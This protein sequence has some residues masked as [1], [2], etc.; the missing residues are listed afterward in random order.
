MAARNPLSKFEQVAPE[1]IEHIA[2][3]T[4]AAKPLGPPSE[5]G[6][7][8]LVS[9][10]LDSVLG[11]KNNAH[12]YA[13]TF[14]L[15]F[16]RSALLRRFSE[17]WRT[18]RCLTSE[19]KKRFIA[20]KRIRSMQ[21]NRDDLWTA[22]LMMLENDGKNGGQLVIWAGVEEFLQGALA[23]RITWQPGAPS[24]WF[25]EME[26]TSLIA[27]LLWLTASRDGVRREG[28]SM[29][30]TIG[31]MLRPFIVAGYK[32]PATFAPDSHF[33]LPLCPHSVFPPDFRKSP[34][35]LT[36]KITHYGHDIHLAVP[37]ITTAATLGTVLR[38]EIRQDSQDLPNDVSSLPRNREEANTVG[39]RGA[40]LE[41]VLEFH[42][43]NRIRV[44][45]RLPSISDVQ[46]YFDEDEE[47]ED[48]GTSQQHDEDWSRLAACYDPWLEDPP[49]RG[50]VYTPGA[51]CG[52]WAGRILQPGFSS[53]LDLLNDSSRCSLHV[54]IYQQPMYLHLQEHHCLHP[55]DPLPISIDDTNFDDILHAWLPRGLDIRR[56]EDHIE[57]Y[58]PASESYIRYETYEP[59]GQAHYSQTTSESLA[60]GCSTNNDRDG[61]AILDRGTNTASGADSL[62]SSYVDN[63][64]E[65][66]DTVSHQCSGIADILITGETGERHG[67][68]WG[69]Y[70]IVGRVRPWDGLVV[71]LRTPVDSTQ[72][73]SGQWV[74]KGYIH[75][76]NLVGRWRETS[77]RV[78]RIG[79][80]GSFLLAKTQE[81]Q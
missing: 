73:H 56:L 58:N 64:Q 53:Y 75:D 2:L 43:E 66:E 26:G 13:S 22:Y 81:S 59:R 27:W 33:H 14:N 35:P 49:L 44:P 77:T 9:R 78:D 54:P 19:L 72:A 80:E 55:S 39:H 12:V 7:L 24:L 4:V 8:C 46:Q 57:V 5:L 21:Y 48:E 50:P 30:S 70:S 34:S 47:D 40:T 65:Y 23:S 3:Y 29:Q 36:R 71:L 42:N 45:E 38:N 52:S 10:R 6:I 63:D 25:T 11:F 60:Q 61:A 79:Y 76:Q 20:L 15:K 51:I 68:A 37:M 41:D 18:T 62:E 74:F 16:D 32:Y 31:N 69:H 67:A 1:I 28:L 17:R